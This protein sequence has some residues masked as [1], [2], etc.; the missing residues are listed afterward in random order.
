MLGAVLS[1]ADRAQQAL[2]DQSSPIVVP[3]DAFGP[4]LPGRPLG[5]GPTMDVAAAGDH[6]FAIGQGRLTVLAGARRGDVT[7]IGGLEGLGN[8]RQIAVSRGYAFITARED[9]LFVVDVRE[10][11]RPRQVAHYDTAELATGIAVAGEIAAV[12]NRFAGVELLDVSQPETPRHLATVRVGEAQSVAF[13]GAWLFAGTWSEKALAVIDVRDPARPRWVRSVPLQGNGDGLDVRGT[14][15]AAATGHHA[16]AQQRPRPGEAA[17]GRGH[18]V[19]F[20]EVSDPAHPR[21]ISRMDFPP[22]YRIGMDMWG[23]VLGGGHAFVNDTHN[24][25]FLVDVRDPERPR[26]AGWHQLPVKRAQGDPSPAAGLAVVGGRAFVA[27]AFDDLHLVETGIAG[28]D[29]P[30]VGTALQAPV[31]A[32][33][34]PS[35][36][37]RYRS[38]GSIR[39]VLP[40][41][42]DRLLV[43]AGSA[44]LHVVRA[45]AEG[46]SPLAV[47]PTRGFVRDVA[48]HGDRVYVAESLGGLSCWER[49]ADGSLQRIGGYAV[50][51]RSIHQVV[52]A[53]EG[54]VGFLAVGGNTLHVVRLA[55]DGSCERLLETTPASGLFYREPIAPLHADG[56]RV[57]V[58]WHAIGLVEYIAENGVVRPTGYRFPHAMDTECG[59]APWRDGWLATSRSGLFVLG[60]E[61]QRSPQEIGRR[62]VAG[63]ARPG[64]PTIDRDIAYVADPF[65]GR[66]AAID[67]ARGGEP[68]LVGD[69]QLS[70]HPGRVRP[71]RGKVLV[72]AG[73]DGLLLW[74]VHRPGLGR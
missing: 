33:V 64:K 72:P 43:A 45:D 4:R 39:A 21:P 56:R 59:V 41:S 63:R 29:S 67:L 38:E 10:P 36:W 62:V 49:K 32:V 60:P 57:R 3:G 55:A 73:R 7:R 5:V 71:F 58:Q 51:G 37:P 9:G 46:F 35:E 11:S 8:T 52:L 27:G 47:Y 53:D 50:P 13:H 66:V 31:S 6:L 44:G 19:E 48:A 12:A 34:P 26:P 22:F 23:A 16:R 74:D 69:L 70:G 40:W 18:G 68:Q 17:W 24:G 30:P 15:L 28:A 61:E 1:A 54:R 65:L 20:W 14:L 2:H 42:D 25:L